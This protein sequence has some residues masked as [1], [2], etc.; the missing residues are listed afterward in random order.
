MHDDAYTGITYT[1]TQQI[2]MMQREYTHTDILIAPRIPRFGK[3]ELTNYQQNLAT[4]IAINTGKQP[5]HIE[6]PMFPF[7]SR[8]YFGSLRY[9]SNDNGV[10]IHLFPSQEYVEDIVY[11]KQQELEEN[12][13]NSLS[14]MPALKRPWL[15]YFSY[16]LLSAKEERI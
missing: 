6:E 10:D 5:S 8:V 2:G 3:K 15:E 13:T 11:K 1:H 12:E 7:L 16:K 9:M 4:R 14:D